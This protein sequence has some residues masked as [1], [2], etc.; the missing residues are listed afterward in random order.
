MR[1]QGEVKRWDRSGKPI[2]KKLGKS[3]KVSF[4]DEV[5]L[6]RIEEVIQVESYKEYNVIKKEGGNLKE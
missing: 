1:R 5:T 2:G 4:K 3:H 6:Q